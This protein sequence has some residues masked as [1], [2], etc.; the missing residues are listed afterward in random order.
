MEVRIVKRKAVWRVK[1]RGYPKP[2]LEW[3][4]NFNRTI[5]S[6]DR[7]EVTVTDDLIVLKIKDLLFSDSGNY[8]L[9]AFNAQSST[10]KIFELAVKGS[11]VVPL[12]HTFLIK[13]NSLSEHPSPSVHVDRPMVLHGDLVTFVCRCTGYPASKIK[14]YFRR[15]STKP[16][17]PTCEST[18][19]AIEVRKTIF[20]RIYVFAWES[21]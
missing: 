2:M 4:D 14:W 8:T 16:E 21:F 1:Y 18:H 13:H 9:K 3:Y 20:C 19:R 5:R 11:S 12:I 10:E 6:G 7:Y 15:C 17:R